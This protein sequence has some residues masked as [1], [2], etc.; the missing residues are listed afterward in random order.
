M[1][2]ILRTDDRVKRGKV[3]FDSIGHQ[4]RAHQDV[5]IDLL[6][7]RHDLELTLLPFFADR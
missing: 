6:L 4:L 7:E 3:V 1:L 2:S 5:V